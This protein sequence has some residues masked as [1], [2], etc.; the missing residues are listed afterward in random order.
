MRARFAR[1]LRYYMRDA[2]KYQHPGTH[3]WSAEESACA[4]FLLQAVKENVE[5]SDEA[6]PATA[7][8]LASHMTLDTLE[9]VWKL[10]LIH[11]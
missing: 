9:R 1:A 7:H 3:V 5:L 8:M 6:V 2:A 11:I 4:D 10:S